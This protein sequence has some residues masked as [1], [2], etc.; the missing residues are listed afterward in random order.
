MTREFFDR[1]GG[2]VFVQGLGEHVI[3]FG[4]FPGPQLILRQ[5]ICLAL[6]VLAIALERNQNPDRPPR[7][8][9]P[10]GNVSEFGDEPRKRATLVAAALGLGG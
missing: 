6:C 4:L 9:Q 3:G 7:G 2:Q 10:F 8:I 5:I 1:A